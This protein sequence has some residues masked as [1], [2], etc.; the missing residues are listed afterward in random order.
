MKHTTR[1]GRVSTIKFDK[2]VKIAEKTE[3]I[4]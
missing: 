4:D 2:E 3:L 1:E